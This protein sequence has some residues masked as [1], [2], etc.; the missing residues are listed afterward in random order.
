M[1]EEKKEDII[2]NEADIE[3]E[4]EEEI[5]EEISGDKKKETFE[6]RIE[7]LEEKNLRLLAEFQ[8]YKRRTDKEKADIYIYA[9]E[10]LITEILVVL[11]NFARAKRAIEKK[12]DKE[13]LQEFNGGISLIEKSINDLLTKEGVEEIKCLEEQFDPNY[14]HAAIMEEVEDVDEGI[15]LEELQKGYKLNG[16]VIRPSMVKVSK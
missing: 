14:H 7:K 8:N 2:E 9:N 13:L 11:D 15:V 10:R 5:V 3:S 1:E 6:E 4:T 12:G 16:K